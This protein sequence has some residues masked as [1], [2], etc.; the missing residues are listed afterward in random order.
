MSVSA[1]HRVDDPVAPGASG[2]SGNA[3]I[4]GTFGAVIFVLLFLEGLTVLRVGELISMHVFVGMLLVPFVLVKIA[5]TG[6]RFV[7]Y[8]GG[9]V[10][11]TRKGPP[12][13]LL[14]LLGPVVVVTTIAL[15][16][17]G[18]G[19]L[20][21]DGRGSWLLFAHKAS[22]VLWFGAMTLHVLGHA[23]ETPGLAV[24]DLRS[25]VRKDAPGATTRIALLAVT[26][27]VGVVLGLVSLGWVH[28]WQAVR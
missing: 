18:I 2:V 9:D 21:T 15:L 13:L 20:L 26:L 17:T 23:L 27:L 10:A 14:R 24:A 5:S 12:P 8:Y 19:A 16:A 6:Y 4:T 7:H 3:R 25:S 22:F 11:Y 28:H 1:R